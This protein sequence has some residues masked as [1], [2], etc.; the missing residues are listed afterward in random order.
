MVNVTIYGIH[1]DP[2]WVMWQWLMIEIGASKM[3]PVDFPSG[4][5]WCLKFVI[6]EFLHLMW[7]ERAQLKTRPKDVATINNICF[8]FGKPYHVNLRQS[9]H[10]LKQWRRKACV[11]KEFE[12]TW[13]NHLDFPLWFWLQIEA[14]TQKKMPNGT[15]TP[16]VLLMVPDVDLSSNMVVVNKLQ[17]N[18]T[19]YGLTHFFPICCCLIPKRISMFKTI[20]RYFTSGVPF[21]KT[22]SQLTVLES[23]ISIRSI[24]F[25]LIVYPIIWQSGNQPE[26]GDFLD[27][28]PPIQ[29]SHHFEGNTMIIRMGNMIQPT[30]RS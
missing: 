9:I 15:L 25:W 27:R 26:K 22:F 5:F 16:P 19:G 10:W 6:S 1:T 12:R 24:F 17:Q 2:S 3:T 18:S 13:K 8:V 14:P 20:L 30:K 23:S 11:R 29:L 28:Q 21:A 4:E 7:Q